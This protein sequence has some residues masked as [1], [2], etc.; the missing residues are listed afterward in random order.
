MVPGA[1]HSLCLLVGRQTR[2]ATNCMDEHSQTI[3]GQRWTLAGCMQGTG[4]VCAGPEGGMREFD[5][6]TRK[7][8]VG[9]TTELE[10]WAYVDD[11]A[12]ATTAELA[13]L[14]MTQLREPLQSHGLE[15]RKDKHCILPNTRES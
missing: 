15:L 8:G 4:G 2:S 10:Y 14:V 7:Q 12:I 1:G 11:I 5:E 9:W 3:C 13:P 6:E